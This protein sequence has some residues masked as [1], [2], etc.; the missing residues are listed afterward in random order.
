MRGFR[1]AAIVLTIAALPFAA[2]CNPAGT[3]RAPAGAKP[4][5]SADQD[6]IRAADLA[7]AAA[8]NAGNVDAVAAVYTDEATLLP[9]NQPPRKGRE[10]IRE[11][12]GGM[13]GAYS[14]RFE[15]ETV[16]IE[17]LGDLAY[18]LG[19]YNLTATP[20]AKGQPA[21][22]EEGKFVEILRRQPDGS[23]KYVVDMYSPNSPPK[24]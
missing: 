21:I 2:G 8:A 20:K 18:A 17:G 13:L 3:D 6:G 7:F 11:F 19:R 1:H 16:A 24:K 10:A 14:V 22:E 5:S 23:W 15:V 12:W 9:P 4:L